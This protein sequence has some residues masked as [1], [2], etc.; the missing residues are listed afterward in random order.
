MIKLKDLA[1][2]LIRKF[3]YEFKP[4]FAT[5]KL[6]EAHKLSI[7]KETVRQLMIEQ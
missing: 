2:S 6:N 1:V 7:S 5:E 4:T 3:Y